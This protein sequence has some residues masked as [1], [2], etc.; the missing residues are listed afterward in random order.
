MNKKLRIIILEDMASEEELVKFELQEAGI[1]FISKWVQTKNEYVQALGDFSPDLILSDYNLP[2]YSGALAFLEAR[3]RCPDVPFILVTGFPQEDD[4]RICERLV[5]GADG[6]VLK[7]HLYRL[8][9]V[10]KKTLGMS[11]AA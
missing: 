3:K 6:Y 7:Q 1:A 9:P 8:A 4:E 2:Q 11:G 5:K 10:V